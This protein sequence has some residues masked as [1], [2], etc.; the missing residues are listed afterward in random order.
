MSRIWSIVAGCLVL[1]AAAHGASF[2]CT[3]ARTK[4][5]GLICSNDEL[6]KLD[7]QLSAAYKTALRDASHAEEIRQDQKKWIA[8]R[9]R[10]SDVSCLNEAY[11]TQIAR[12]ALGMNVQL[13]I[14]ERNPV[15]AEVSVDSVR[16]IDFELNH[17]VI[18]SETP[19]RVLDGLAR[20][21]INNDGHSEIVVRVAT[22]G[23]GNC[24]GAVFLATTD[25]SRTLIPDTKLNRILRE[26][27][28]CGIDDQ[29]I[30]VLNGA[31]YV[32]AKGYQE[33]TVYQI[34]G[35]RYEVVCKFWTYP[36]SGEAPTQ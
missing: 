6:S 20:V 13:I 21:D 14:G 31:S 17:A 32:D 16:H 27:G 3:K 10:C 19:S 8:W 7:D 2:D 4:T 12:L 23:Y 35:D 11:V 34:F 36:T 1:A 33:R 24:G 26:L 29:D 5:E 28:T 22:P 9:E 25:E 18:R 30:F 15:C